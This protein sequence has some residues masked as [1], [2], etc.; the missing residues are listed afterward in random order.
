MKLEPFG[1]NSTLI[2]PLEL[3]KGMLEIQFVMAPNHRPTYSTLSFALI[4]LA[5]EE[6]TGKNYSQLLDELVIKPLGLTNTG[7][8][9]GNDEKAV[10]PLTQS[11]WGAD[12]GLNAP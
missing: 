3:L 7:V 12:Y 9:P 2:L 6:A 8:S 11:S 10:I 5:L 4:A 1:T